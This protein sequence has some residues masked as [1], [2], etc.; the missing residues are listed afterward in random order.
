MSNFDDIK[1]DIRWENTPLINFLNLFDKSFRNFNIGVPKNI[2]DIKRI[3]VIGDGE[4]V[5]NSFKSELILNNNNYEQLNS[6]LSLPTIIHNEKAFSNGCFKIKYLNNLNYNKIYLYVDDE[7]LY[8]MFLNKNLSQLFTILVNKGRIPSRVSYEYVD[9]DDAHIDVYLITDYPDSYVFDDALGIFVTREGYQEKTFIESIEE[10]STVINKIYDNFFGI[11]WGSS[12]SR[13]IIPINHK[14]YFF[15]YGAIDW[16]AG[17][18][19]LEDEF[20]FENLQKF[21]K[22]KNIKNIQDIS[23]EDFWSFCHIFISRCYTSSTSGVKRILKHK[24]III[25]KLLGFDNINNKQFKLNSLHYN[26]VKKDYYFTRDLSLGQV[27]Q[28]RFITQDERNYIDRY[29]LDKQ[30]AGGY[31]WKSIEED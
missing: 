8:L 28:F 22:I 27:L 14:Y 13:R 24:I 18:S 31:H 9:I 12:S 10:G 20:F 7:Y 6:I 25:N 29:L 15:K 21:L 16:Y 5:N 1:N 26:A 3:F 2:S 19:S 23:D 4:E 17:Y 30:T 11:S